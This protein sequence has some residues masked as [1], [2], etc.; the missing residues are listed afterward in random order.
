MNSTSRLTKLVAL[1][2][3]ILGLAIPAVASASPVG[4]TLGE[5]HGSPDT[6]A[7]STS[8][9]ATESGFDWGAY[10]GS[11]PDTSA[12]SGTVVVAEPGFDWGD[13]AI[14]ASLA[15]AVIVIGTGCVLV[16]RELRQD[17]TRFRVTG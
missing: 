9:V 8:I 6:S 7:P 4:P 15:L 10:Q 17:R 5:Y 14:G 16:A 12:P 13:A 1:S 11:P 3:T 2:L